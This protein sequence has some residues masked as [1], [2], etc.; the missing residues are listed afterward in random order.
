MGELS[1][2]ALALGHHDC[3]APGEGI[4]GWFLYPIIMLY[5][6][7]LLAQ[8]CDGH[9]TLAL[10][11]IVEKTKMPEDVA[12]ATFLAMA[13]SAPELFCS[14]VSTF[15]LVS[16]NGVG[17]IVGSAVFN[18]LVIIGVVPI[19]SGTTLKIWWYPTVR[20]S[21]F[22]SI[23]IIEV[24]VVLYDGIVYW[25]DA[26]IMVLS[27]CLYVFYFTQNSRICKHYGIKPPDDDEVRQIE[28]KSQIVCAN[29]SPEDAL[30]RDSDQ[31]KAKVSKKCKTPGTG[32]TEANV[33]EED[34][35][36][37]VDSTMQGD[38]GKGV[39]FE[40]AAF[41]VVPVVPPLRL[42]P[43]QD[44]LLDSNMSA[45]TPPGQVQV[46]MG[47][48]KQQPE[49]AQESE[50]VT[51]GSDERHRDDEVPS[52]EKMN[53]SPEEEEEAGGWLKYEPVMFALSC[54]M[55]SS[56]DWLWTL[57][58]LCCLVIGGLTYFA[59]DAADR[60]GCLVG[61]SDVAMGLV[62]LAAGTS[63]PDAMG[64]IAVAKSGMGD[65]AVAN[66]VGSNT[67]DILLGLGLPW[68]LKTAMYEP[69]KVPAE[70]LLEAVVTLACCL[71]IYLVALSANGMKLNKNLGLGLLCLYVA[72]IIWFLVRNFEADD[73]N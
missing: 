59:V 19:F 71:I 18:L 53:T 5:M 69:I 4:W 28:I 61:I 12:G 8:I 68:F 17:N 13:S 9:L 70:G 21:I 44:G 10:E 11:F 72:V 50:G 34:E 51:P 20:D 7:F 63:I 52:K 56:P 54:I 35:S 73:P 41:S 23:A 26:F 24:F 6:F 49:N 3:D 29:N 67:F 33:S 1:L 64:S 62:F 2:W 14:I 66:A 25:P 47:S 15:V 46:A 36:E 57:F 48:E 60:L 42:S 32:E 22:Y 16:A 27:Y 31:V 55:P 43:S 58:T 30:C 45:C 37:P 39:E 38:P 40:K 65:M